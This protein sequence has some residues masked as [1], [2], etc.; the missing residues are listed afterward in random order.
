MNL[1]AVIRS[2]FDHRAAKKRERQRNAIVKAANEGIH[3]K[4]YWRRKPAKSAEYIAT[5]SRL[6]A[7]MGKPNPLRASVGRRV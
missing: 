4:S 3:V 2:W 7:E 5:T 6:A 1:T